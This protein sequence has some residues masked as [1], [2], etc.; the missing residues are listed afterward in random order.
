M[1][2]EDCTKEELIWYIK[3]K[4][5]Y[6][7]KELLFQVLL[8]RSCEVSKSAAQAGEE[9]C[10]A[11]ERYTEAL[12]PYEGGSYMDVPDKVII[13]ANRAFKEYEKYVAV[14]NRYNRQHERIQKQIDKLL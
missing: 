10:K 9:A 4:V 13:K 8:H 14:Y 12:R 2:L 11:L 7:E 1:I 5:F 3:T 6:N